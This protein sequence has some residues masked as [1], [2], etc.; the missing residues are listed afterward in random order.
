MKQTKI[1]KGRKFCNDFFL[2]A[3]IERNR[4]KI[5]EIGKNYDAS[6]GDGINIDEAKKVTIGF[7]K[8]F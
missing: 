1:I 2:Q 4:E 8:F 5:T 3:I 7:V 6:A